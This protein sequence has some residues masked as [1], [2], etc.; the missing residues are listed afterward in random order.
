MTRK[1][2]R[3]AW[4]SPT[5][6]PGT[7]VRILRR[8]CIPIPPWCDGA[9]RR[10]GAPPPAPA[11]S[12]RGGGA[13]GGCCA[14]L[15]TGGRFARRRPPHP[16]GVRPREIPRA[17]RPGRIES[18]NPENHLRRRNRRNGGGIS[19]EAESGRGRA[20]LIDPADRTFRSGIARFGG[21]QPRGAMHRRLRKRMA[22]PRRQQEPNPALVRRPRLRQPGPATE[23]STARTWRFRVNGVCG[24]RNDHRRRADAD[25]KNG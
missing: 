5:P 6:W 9:G 15:P 1:D 22:A 11:G 13:P 17:R 24:Y 25:H 12:G 21:P 19:M 10:R 18:G 16:V 8:L 14:R 20:R 4:H 3:C 7:P 2:S 23:V